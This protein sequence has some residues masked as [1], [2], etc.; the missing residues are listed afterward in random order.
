MSDKWQQINVRLEAPLAQALR[1][2]KQGHDESLA[3]VILRLL[4]KEVRRQAA[5][6][7]APVGRSNAKG[8][9]GRGAAFG[10]RGK[11][12]PG[13]RAVGGRAVGGRAA[14][15]RG[16]TR[17]P[18]APREA[19]AGRAWGA[20]GAKGGP[21]EASAPPRAPRTFG[22][23]PKP[24][25][26][27]PPEGSGEAPKRAFRARLEGRRPFRASDEPETAEARPRRPRKA[28]GSRSGNG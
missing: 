17:K 4:W 10:R 22:G 21:A 19:P 20:E 1:D 8:A 6:G 28:K 7:G 25:R 11:A 3:E 15:G 13:G 18:F 26:P 5:Q 12:A 23:K 24:F 9:G 27:A 14:G 16:G 2:M